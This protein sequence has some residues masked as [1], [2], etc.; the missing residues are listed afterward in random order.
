MPRARAA[1]GKRLLRVLDE[2]LWFQEQ[3]GQH[4]L[5]EGDHPTIADIACF[6]YTALSED[7]DLP[8]EDYPAV[9][10][11]HDRFKRIE[12]FKVMSGVFPARG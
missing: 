4:W 5:V 2:H 3:A 7:A 6:P 1:A 10:R 9:R 12:G 11:W 8:R